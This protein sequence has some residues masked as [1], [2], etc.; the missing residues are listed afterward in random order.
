MDKVFDASWQ[1][2]VQENLRRGCDTHELCAILVN[3]GFTL[4]VI[5]AAM[6]AAFPQGAGAGET[7]DYQALCHIRLT[8][9]GLVPAAIPFPS[10]KLQLYTLDDFMAEAECDRLAGLIQEHLRRSTVTVEHPTDPYYRTSSTSDLSLLQ[11]PAVQ[12]LAE[13]IA[14]TMGIAASHAEGLQGQHYAVGQEFKAHT[15]FFA[16]GTAEYHQFAATRGNRTWTFMLY[17]NEVEAGGGTH[18]INIH[19]IFQPKKGKAVA[20]NNLRSDGSPNPDTL[21]SGM[22]VIKGHKTIITQWFRER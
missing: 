12:A 8:Q 22:P 20:W 14:A 1:G 5:K 13:K 7:P 4:P 18:F 17:L 21:H 2:W 16:P 15:D 11:H 19:H 3:N 10:P 6:G 9:A